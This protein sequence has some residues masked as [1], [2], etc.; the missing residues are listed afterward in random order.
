MRFSGIL[1]ASPYFAT[2]SEQPS[3]VKNWV[4]TGSQRYEDQADYQEKSGRQCPPV[5]LVS[6]QI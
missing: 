3:T 5:V 1:G 4:K 6:L 2:T